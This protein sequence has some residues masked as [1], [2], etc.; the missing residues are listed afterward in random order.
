DVFENDA[1]REYA[2]G[3]VVGN[4]RLVRG[5]SVTTDKVRIRVSGGKVVPALSEVALFLE[6]VVLEA[7]K[8][9]RDKFGMVT[10][11][12]ASGGVTVRYTL[13]G[14]EPTVSG[15]AY[16]EPL[17]LTLGGVVKC[18]AFAVSG[19]GGETSTATFGLTKANWKIAGASPSKRSNLAI[20]DNPDSVC[21][22]EKKTDSTVPLWIAVNLGESV[23]IAAFTVMPI[24]DT[25]QGLVD[26]YRFEVS[27]DGKAWT[28]VA[29]GEFSNIKANPIEQTVKLET[30]VSATF[31]RFTAL[32]CVIGDQA[33]VAELGVIPAK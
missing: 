12:P 31:F 19:E 28:Q 3:E 17:D 20:D 4:C 23:K 24:T 18:R 29:E 5:A 27:G 22:G 10:I 16:S 30:P 26:R 32:R 13:D 14:S 7:P 2:K 11:T 1:W 9:L 25:D 21:I 8:I 15:P 6:P 33:S